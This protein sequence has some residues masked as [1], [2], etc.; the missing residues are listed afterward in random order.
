VTAGR[1]L[2]GVDGGNTKTVAAVATPD[3][4][5]VGT[6]RILRGS[7]IYAVE[8]EAAV[9]IQLEVADRAL[10]AAEAAQ[11]GPAPAAPAAPSADEPGGSRDR[12]GAAPSVSA[13]FSLAGADWPEDIALLEGRLGARWPGAVVV[14]DAIG[15]L[16]AAIPDGPGVVVVCGTGAATG[17]R[18]P[19]GRTWHSSFWQEPQGAH[20]LGVRTLQAIARAELGIDPPTALT[21]RVLAA[22]GEPDV[23]ALLHHMHGRETANRRDPAS[24]AWVLLETAAAGDPA[25][26]AIVE[27]HG[28]ELGRTALAA[29]RRTGIDLAGPFALA[30]SGGVLRHP[31]AGLR[32]AIASTVRA[33]AP[34]AELVGPPPE[35]VAGAVLLA[36]DAAG[37]PASPE[38]RAR[39]RE[40]LAATDLYET[41]PVHARR[42]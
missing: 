21:E 36:F 37:L 8:P 16:R 24:L 33:G 13:A 27:T 11:A 5:I 34:L 40:G 29:A 41:H 32:Q 17:A 19:D 42:D 22:T 7:D 35:P 26:T 10:A 39:I 30:L 28:A 2:L 6:A 18:G 4:T 15:A 1:L 20:E 14:N 31:S 23:E 25:A 12:A 3:G 38:I 9:A